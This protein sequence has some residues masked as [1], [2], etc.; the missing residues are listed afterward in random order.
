[1]WDVE[2]QKLLTDED[3]ASWV[4]EGLAALD[5]TATYL[6]DVEAELLFDLVPSL[7]VCVPILGCYDWGLF[8]FPITTTEEAFFM[9]FLQT[10]C[11]FHCRFPNFW[12]KRSILVK[13]M[14]EISSIIRSLF[15]MW[16]SCH[17]KETCCFFG[18][19]CCFSPIF[20]FYLRNSEESDGIVLTFAP[21]QAGDFSGTLQFISNDPYT[22]LIQVEVRGTA[23]EEP[24]EE[25]VVDETDNDNAQVDGQKAKSL[26]LR[27]RFSVLSNI[28]IGYFIGIERCSSGVVNDQLGLFWRGI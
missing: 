21:D 5:V 2:G 10:N 20:R 28:A 1:M 6:A 12:M 22:P 27:M 8:E 11:I 7:E 26:G 15:P 4:P 17:W 25:E 24:I 9:P 18:G 16:E 14:S 19:W 13:C 3:Y 23:I